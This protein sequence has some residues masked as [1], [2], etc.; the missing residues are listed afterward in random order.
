[1]MKRTPFRY[2]S[3]K[4]QDFFDQSDRQVL[5]HGINLVDKNPLTG[6]L[7]FRSGELFSLF[8]EWGFNCIRLGVI[9]DGLE[10]TPGKFNEAYL[11]GIDEQ[12]QFASQNDL[13]VFLDMHQDLYSRLY[14]DGAPAW[15]TI[16]GGAQHIE[17]SQVWSDAYFTSP[18]VR[19]ALDNF[20]NNAPAPDGLGLQEHY[21]KA[22]AVLARRYR[23]NPTVIGYDLM[24]EPFPGSIALKAQ[25]KM[26]AKGAEILA[27]SGLFAQEPGEAVSGNHH[28]DPVESLM[29]FWLSPEGR[30]VILKIL[31]DLAIYVPIIDEQQEIY[32]Q[33]ECEKLMGMYQRV[34]NAIRSE[35]P[36]GLL[37]LET[38]MASNMGVFSAL[39][40]VQRLEG[41]RDPYQ[42]YS[43]H[44]YDLVTDT[45]DV[46]SACPERVELIFKRHA[47]TSRRLGMP[48]LVG[49]WGAYGSQPETL[50][51]AWKVVS[52][53]ESLL[54]SETYWAYIPGIEHTP[55]FQAVQ[56]PYPQRISGNLVQYHYD[57]DQARFTC[58]WQESGLNP[59]PSWIYM[60]GWF[61]FD[62]SGVVLTPEGSGYQVF[63]T[64]QSGSMILF[65][66]PIGHECLRILECSA[67]N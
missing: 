17:A 61:N 51:T 31:S 7:E 40:P 19:T 63:H 56:R 29:Q 46:H 13:V 39:E 24:N 30:S 22:W 47:E 33:F 67:K 3:I 38:S 64:G 53:F 44:G 20:W 49:E 9:W 45:A 34:A 57:P 27:G 65:I 36:D 25:E 59:E 37:F 60:P 11:E 43:P 21:A 26:F 58:R 35:D 28:V 50:E 62:R 8:R 10:P 32:N 54:C 48:M 18:A 15:A 55:S 23:N 12:I 14:S 66:P 6:Y 16:T 1:M 42:V 4:N 5:L 2:L 52:L 41:G